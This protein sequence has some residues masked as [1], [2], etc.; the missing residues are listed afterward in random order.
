MNQQPP[1][2]APFITVLIINYNA[3]DRLGEVLASLARQTFSDFEI[4]LLDNASTDGSAEVAPPPGLAFRLV[5]NDGN[6]GFAGGVMD[7]L[8]HLKGTWIAILNP[9]AYPAPDWL[10]ALARAAAAY[11]RLTALGSVQVDHSSPDR[12]DGLGD[13]YHISGVAWRGGFGKSA[14]LRPSIDKEIFAPCFAA[15]LLHRDT[16][17][18]HGGL[19]RSFFCYHEDV[20]FG[21]RHRLRGGRAVLVHD[22]VVRHE[23]SGTTGRYS[24]FTVFHGIRNRQWTFVKNMPPALLVIGLPFAAA[25]GIAFWVRSAMLGIER[26]YRQGV[27]AALRD[28]RRVLGDRKAVQRQRKVSSLSLARAITWSPLAPLRRAP[29][30][31][32]VT[33]TSRQTSSTDATN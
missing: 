16:F 19:D 26:P 30:L 27:V 14:T 7:A 11:G 31:R 32:P 22:A 9:D 24:D 15:C 20:D 17:V 33:P 10:A 2:A 28:L 13:A 5:R 6:T 1:K 25:L 18:D 8:P 3:G 21:F 29:H 23:G 12:L 4:V